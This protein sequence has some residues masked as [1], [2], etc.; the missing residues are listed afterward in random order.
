M[1]G[2]FLIE[3]PEDAALCEESG[4]YEFL[5]DEIEC[6][7][8]AMAIGPLADAF[9]PCAVLSGSAGEAWPVCVDCIAPMIFPGDWSEIS[10]EANF[11]IPG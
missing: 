2:L 9:V 4:I 7:N 5:L 1:Y 10:I 6:E 11:D 8:C 3:T